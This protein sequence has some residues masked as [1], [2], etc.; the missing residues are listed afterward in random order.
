MDLPIDVLQAAVLFTAK[1]H[2]RP[3]Y[4]VV[5]LND[6][7]IVATDGHRMFW[8]PWPTI[9][10]DLILPRETIINLVAKWKKITKKDRPQMVQL[11]SAEN[12]YWTLT[13]TVG[14]TEMFYPVHVTYPD[15]RRA[16][17]PA[18]DPLTRRE[19]SEISFNWDYLAY[20]AKASTLIQGKTPLL[21]QAGA[22]EP[23]HIVFNSETYP[24]AKA[25]IQPM[26][27]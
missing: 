11:S 7:H 21:I 3:C 20:A 5:A 23:G 15:W 18:P 24:E 1:N 14:I 17:K 26:R 8:C 9:K 16:A 12:G 25:I 22:S 2:I 19:T 6:R 4:N 10:Q 27:I 13:L